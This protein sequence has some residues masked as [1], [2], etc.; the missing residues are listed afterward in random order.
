MV[1][2]ADQKIGKEALTRFEDLLKELE[3]LQSQLKQMR[4]AA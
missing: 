2:Q 4:L 3:T 1:S